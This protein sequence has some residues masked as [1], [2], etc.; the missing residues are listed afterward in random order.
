MRI[1]HTADW[2]LGQTFHGHERGAE[3]E[4]FLAWLT[5]LLVA[6]QVDALVVAGDVFDTANPPSSAQHQLHRFVAEVRRRAPELELVFIAGNHDSAARLEAPRPLL[7][8]FGVTVVGTLP[9]DADGQL[10]PE[11]MVVALHARG[12]DIG[13]WCLAVPYQR[14][15]ELARAGQPEH[16]HA[17][18]MRALYDE[19]LAV[20]LERRSAGQPIIALGHC[21][22]A[23]GAVSELSER[24]IVIGGAEALP[25]DVFD[26]RLR[27]VALGHLHRPQHVGHHEHIR[28]SGSPLPMSFAELDYPHQVL[29]IDLD[30]DAPPTL[31]PWLIPR[32]VDLLRI[33][34]AA[35]APLAEVLALLEDLP[36]AT[37]L[38]E[39]RLPYLE[40]RVLLTAPE[41]GLR[42]RVETAVCNK[43]V[44]LARLTTSSPQAAPGSDSAQPDA[45]SGLEQLGP[46]QV[47]RQMHV[48]RFGDEP[49]AEL[50]HV[51]ALLEAQAAAPAALEE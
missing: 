39:H 23:G 38:P 12:G 10:A 43:A 3:H 30:G 42:S 27:Y 17:A 22:L 35:P 8:A 51:F 31:R 34:R 7:A 44:R 37:E 20:A 45:L 29:C 16:A 32:T 9:R 47:F 33:P 2:H 26:A 4:D 24:R 40:V 13:A 6:E 15:G 21:H 11:G 14:P 1:V 28:Y 49:T 25:A 19:A 36:L 48:A 41:P 50:L 46:A 5:D 18:A